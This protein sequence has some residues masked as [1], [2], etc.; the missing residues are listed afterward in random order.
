MPQCHPLN[1][2]NERELSGYAGFCR[3]LPFCFMQFLRN[4]ARFVFCARNCVECTGY[5]PSA[6]FLS[7]FLNM[8]EKSGNSRFFAINSMSSAKFGQIRIL[9]KKLCRMHWLTAFSDF[10]KPFLD[11]SQKCVKIHFFCN[12]FDEIQRNLARF[13]FCARNYVECTD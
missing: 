9:R 10:S 12:N 3:V 13:V 7:H 4:L 1:D 2:P 5:Q 6:I 11:M 8:S